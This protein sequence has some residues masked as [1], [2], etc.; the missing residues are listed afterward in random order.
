MSYDGSTAPGAPLVYGQKVC[1]QFH[2]NLGVVGLLASARSGR[3]QLSTQVINKQ[4]AYMQAIRGDAPSY[5][6][7]FEILPTQVDQRIISNGTPVVAGA[8]FVLV[9]CFTNKRLACVN[10]S[11]STDFGSECALCVHTYTE[12]GKVNKLMR[13]TI[14]RPTN[15]LISREETTE[16]HWGVIYA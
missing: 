6:C 1:L 8:P 7:A 13:E 5:D 9:H 15:N 10:V 11:I 2:E 3:T 12:T 14:G 4:E 16:N